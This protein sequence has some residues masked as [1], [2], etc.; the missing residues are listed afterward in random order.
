MPSS[1]KAAGSP[2]QRKRYSPSSSF[3]GLELAR[4]ED[5]LRG[6]GD[7]VAGGDQADVAAEDPLQHRA[8]E[9]VVGAAEDHRV[10]VGALAAARSRSAPCSTT[11]SE[12]G[13]PRWMIAARSGAATWVT[14][15]SRC[16]RR[17]RSQVGAALDGRRRREHADPP[18]VGDRRGDLGLGLDHGDHLDP[19]LGGDLARRSRGRRAPPSCRRSRSASRRARAGS[20]VLRSTHSRSSATRLG[21]V[22][23]A[24][25]VAEVDVVLLGQRDEAL[26][27]HGEAADPGVEDGDRQRG[28]GCIGVHASDDRRCET[29]AVNDRAQSDDSRLSLWSQD[30]ALSI[31][32]QGVV[33]SRSDRSAPPSR[34]DRSSSIEQRLL[35]RLGGSRSASAFSAATRALRSDCPPAS[36]RRTV[37]GDE[38]SAARA[39]PRAC[40]PAGAHGD[41]AAAV[42]HGSRPRS[43]GVCRR[44][45]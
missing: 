35:R 31:C 43:R 36:A 12:N 18:G 8:H 3:C 32:S 29:A 41:A 25:V 33:S 28:V 10:D 21:A 44:A 11:S 16:W 40:W 22:G 17:E 38:H 7:R 9:R 13:K 27:E 20:A 24:G 2:V 1:R 14:V 30:S 42:W 34:S 23:K 15:S 19:V 39:C 5:A 26:V 45:A 4:L 6:R 37:M